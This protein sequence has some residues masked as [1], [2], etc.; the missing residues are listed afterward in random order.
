VAADTGS[1][2]LGRQSGPSALRLR[3][4]FWGAEQRD[5]PEQ[6]GRAAGDRVGMRVAGGERCRR[7]DVRQGDFRFWSNGE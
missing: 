1:G 6:R 4:G 3:G 2:N 5:V 7:G